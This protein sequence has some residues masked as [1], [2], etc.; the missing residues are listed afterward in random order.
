MDFDIYQ[1]RAMQENIQAQDENKKKIERMIVRLKEFENIETI[2]EAKELA[3]KILPVANEINRFSV[4]D[5]KCTVINRDDL[6]RISFDTPDEF[7][8]YD[9]VS[10]NK[11]AENV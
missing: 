11:Q 2:E 5:A 6:F 9:F 1:M 7:I 4:G 10:P 8:S 3:K